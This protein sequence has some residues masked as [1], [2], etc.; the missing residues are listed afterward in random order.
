[1]HLPDEAEKM[2]WPFTENSSFYL[3]MNMSL[4]SEGSWAG[5]AD[6]MGLPA[7]MEVDWIRVSKP[8]A[9]KND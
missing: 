2:Q 3:I 4:G 7:I 9:N 5:P 8:T 1:M 6:D